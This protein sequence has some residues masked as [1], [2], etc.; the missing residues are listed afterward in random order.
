MKRARVL[1]PLLVLLGWLLCALLA[2]VLPLSP[3]AIDL[4]QGFAPPE[5]AH[6]LGTDELGR[7]IAARVVSGARVSCG[8]GVAVMLLSLGIGVDA[9][10]SRLIDIFMAFPGILLA[11]ALAG[12]LGPGL[13]NVVL[14]LCAV[15]WVGFA[16][17]ARAQTLAVKARDHVLAARALGSPPRYVVTRHVLPL[18][19]AP[20]LVEA[21]FV[22]AGAVV[23]EAGLSFLGLGAQP[24][25]AS[26]GSMIRQAMQFLLVA[27]HML[28]GPCLALVSLVLASN[29]LGDHLRQLRQ[30]T[31]D[32]A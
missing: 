1:L 14:A 17:L 9:C 2:N 32:R 11:I 4:A 3:N 27:P 30:R 26:W 12:V 20:L 8:V 16:R 13:N 18:I 7:S 23:A 31:G 25:L 6:W 29:L 24:P 5:A 22:L 21:S 15:S 19:A 10:C 28:I